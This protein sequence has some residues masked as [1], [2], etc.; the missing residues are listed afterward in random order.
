VGRVAPIEGLGSRNILLSS[1]VGQEGSQAKGEAWTALQKPKKRS[2]G[3]KLGA[4]YGEQRRKDKIIPRFKRKPEL[5]FASSYWRLPQHEWGRREEGGCKG[6]WGELSVVKK[7]RGTGSVLGTEKTEGRDGVEAETEAAR[8]EMDKNPCDRGGNGKK[9][10]SETSQG[11]KK[12]DRV[13]PS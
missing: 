5:S 12:T 6:N 10:S 13:G 7:G 11:K 8:I 3:E 9:S 4:F 2:E 1:A